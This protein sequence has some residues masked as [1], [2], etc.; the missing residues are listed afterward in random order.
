VF[1]DEE[2]EEKL[3]LRTELASDVREEAARGTTKRI[4][5]RPA[6]VQRRPE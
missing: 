1:V 3:F 5:R 2:E 4:D 6:V